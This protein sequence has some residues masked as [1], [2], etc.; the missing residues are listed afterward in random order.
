M[1]TVIGQMQH[2]GNNEMVRPENFAQSIAS[3]MINLALVA[4]VGAGAYFAF[5]PIVA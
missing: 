2:K 3:V 4:S 1:T 5:A